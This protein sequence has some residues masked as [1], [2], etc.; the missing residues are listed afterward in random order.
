MQVGDKRKLL[1]STYLA[2]GERITGMIKPNL[3]LIF[4][5]ELLEVSTRD[6]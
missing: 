3:N 4:G 2:Y 5:I 6:D 1:M